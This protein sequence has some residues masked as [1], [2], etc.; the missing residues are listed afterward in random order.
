MLFLS[1]I[2]LTNTTKKA[3]KSELKGDKGAAAT[4]DAG[5]TTTLAAG[6]SATVTNIGTTAAAIFIL[7]LLFRKVFKV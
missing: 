7:T 6:Q 3:L 1:W 5:T 2:W 4:V